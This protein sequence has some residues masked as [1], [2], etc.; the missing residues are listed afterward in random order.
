MLSDSLR[1]E[2]LDLDNCIGVTLD[3]LRLLAH[4]DL[5]G[6]HS[7][8]SQNVEDSGLT[9]PVDADLLHFG[10]ASR[11]LFARV[12]LLLGLCEGGQESFGNS[13]THVDVSGVNVAEFVAQEQ[14][15][16]L[17]VPEHAGEEA[18]LRVLQLKDEVFLRQILKLSRIVTENHLIVADAE[19]HALLLNIE[20]LVDS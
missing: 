5:K 1:V 17:L 19:R 3:V 11:D 4:F 10:T 15:L 8:L 6:M 2:C 14:V 20:D 16:L 18:L 12:L 13:F 7:T 9:R